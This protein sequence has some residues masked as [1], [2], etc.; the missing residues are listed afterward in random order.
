MI[1]LKIQGLTLS[2]TKNEAIHVISQLQT[3]INEELKKSS[4]TTIYNEDAK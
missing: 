4:Q 3:Q 2:L 1:T